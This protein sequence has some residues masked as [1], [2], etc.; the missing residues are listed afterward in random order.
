MAETADASA[1]CPWLLRDI[2]ELQNEPYPNIQFLVHDS[3]HDACLILRP[4]Q[5]K[6]PHLTVG[7]GRYP[8]TAPQVTIQSTVAHPNVFGDYI[9]ASILDT[10]EGY[11]PAYT[12]KSIAV[13]LLSFFSSESLEQERGHRVVD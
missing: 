12:L 8:F 13:Q 6:S 11:T 10:T 4:D 5:S 1:S 7:F 9:C 3:L 2:A